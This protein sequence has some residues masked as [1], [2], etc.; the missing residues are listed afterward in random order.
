MTF[1]TAF[2]AACYSHRVT[3]NT[4]GEVGCLEQSWGQWNT[5]IRACSRSGA[6]SKNEREIWGKLR[7]ATS[8]ANS[9]AKVHEN[10]IAGLLFLLSSHS[11]WPLKSFFTNKQMGQEIRWPHPRPP[12][13]A[14]LL[15]FILFS[16]ELYQS[17]CIN[18]FTLKMSQLHDTS[19]NERVLRCS[20]SP[21]S[22]FI[23]TR[24]TRIVD[25]NFRFS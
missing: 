6:C 18:F 19:H 15:S 14:F 21:A 5:G 10:A 13:I 24:I 2:H 9:A 4:G 1:H 12:T 3:Y 25:S 17:V 11:I 20:S 16:L 7:G 8:T 23:V 22:E